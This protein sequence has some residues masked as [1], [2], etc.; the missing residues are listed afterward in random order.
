MNGLI[1]LSPLENDAPCRRRS[2]WRAACAAVLS[3]VLAVTAVVVGASPASAAGDAR[4]QVVAT[5]ID[6][7][8]GAAIS[9]TGPGRYGG[10]V[11]FKVDFSCLVA[12]CAGAT[13]RLDPTQLDPNLNHY[14]LLNQSGFVPP[15]MGATISGSAAA[16]YTVALGDLAAGQ[17]GSFTVEY[18]QA[19]RPGDHLARRDGHYNGW[20]VANFPIGFP[21]VQRVTGDATTSAGP[22]SH[23]SEPVLWEN[24]VPT[25]G[26]AQS[27][28]AGQY[29]TDT[30]YTY[31]LYMA[32]G[33]TSRVYNGAWGSV[34]ASLESLCAEKYE[35]VHRIP[36][37]V[38][39]VAASGDP[40]VSGSIDDGFVLTWQ[41]DRSDW[42]PTDN[43]EPGWQSL[44]SR[45]EDNA[46]SPRTVTVRFPSTSFAPAG[47]D[48][49]FTAATGAWR[50]DLTVGYIG[51]PGEE[52]VVKNSTMGGGPTTVRCTSEPASPFGKAVADAKTSTF[53]GTARLSDGDS[54][55]VVPRPG[56][57]DNEKQ[58]QVT[59]GN[60]AN[61]PG[62]AVVTDDKLDLPDAPVHRIETTP[63]GASVAWTAT[64]GTETVSGTSASP[65]DAPA[66]FRF[67]SAV[68]TSPSL[69]GPNTTSAQA[70][71]TNFSVVYKYR[72]S[73]TAPPGERRT[74]EASAVM[75][76]PSDSTVDDIA[77]KVPSHTIRFAKP[78]GKAEAAKASSVGTLTDGE[79]RYTI[80]TVGTAVANWSVDAHNR[81]NV[82]GR[83]V[84]QE[85]VLR[86]PGG[87]PVTTVAGGYHNGS[88]WV[89]SAF[90]LEYTLDDGTKG[91]A[92]VAAGQT[93]AAP[94][95]RALASARITSPE[96][97]ARNS[98]P[99][100]NDQTIFRA[101]FGYVIPATAQPDAV[102]KNTATVTM[103][104]PDHPSLDDI[105]KEVSATVRLVG[106]I[107]TFNAS[108]VRQALPGGA[109]SAGP[110]TTVTYRVSGS[111]SGV[112]AGRTITSQYVF[113]A[114]EGWVIVPGSASFAPGTVPVGV[115]F[116]Y[117][118]VT[119]DGVARQAV[120]AEWPAGTATAKNA[121]LPAMTVA[122][123]PGV[124]VPTGTLSRPDAFIGN[125]GDPVSTDVFATPLVDAPDVDR[126][127]DTT[128]RFARANNAGAGT[129]VA[130]QP[131]LQVLKEICLPDRG[132]ADGCEWI[133]DPRHPVGVAPNSTSIKYRLSIT[134]I[135]NATLGD[136]VGYD[137]LPY[138]GDTGTSDQT[139]AIQRGSTFRLSVKSVTSPTNG[140]EVEF[141]T[142]TQPCRSEV[143]AAVPG[144]ADDWSATSDGAQSI[145][146]SRQGDL[147]PGQ[148]ISVE[149]TGAVHDAPANG[150]IACNSFAV[151]AGSLATVSEPAA[152]CATIQETDLRIA[153]EPT[154]LQVGRP[155]VLPFTV[156]N[157]GGA[158]SAMGKVVV[159]IPKGV[160][161]T[162]LAPA[163]WTCTAVDGAGDPAFGTAVGP[164]TLTCQP[165]AAF[166]MDAPVAL[167]IPVIPTSPSF[168]VSAE[169]AGQIH[170]GDLTNNVA[171][172][173]LKPV[174]AVS[175]LPVSKNDGVA[176][177]APGQEL[178]YTIT[179]R[180]PLAYEAL[181][182]VELTDELPAD[183]E[184]ISASDGGSNSG[185]TVS[186]SLPEI[187]AGGQIVRSVTLRVLPT[188]GTKEMVNT[189]RGTAPDPVP[190]SNVTITGTGEDRD[191]VM[192]RPELSVVKDSV[193]K[194]FGAAGQ[195]IT[196]QFTV[197]NSGDV[198]IRDIELDDPLPGLT[199][200]KP[201]WPTTSG[202]LAPGES[203]TASATYL[204]TQDDID[205]GTL[206]NTATATGEAPDGSAVE[207]SVTHTLPGVASAH[208]LFDKSSSGTPTKAGD[209][210]SYTFTVENDGGVTLHDVTVTDVMPGLSEPKFS[211]PGKPN[212]LAPGTK[213]T[214][215]ASYTVRQSDVD[216]GRVVNSATASGTPLVGA[217]VTAEDEVTDLIDRKPGIS[218][219]KR[220]AHEEGTR[221]AVGDRLL[222]S[223]TIANTGNV[224]LSDVDI[225]DE[226]PGLSDIDDTWPAEKNV[227][228]PGQFATATAEYTITQADVDALT[229][230]VNHATVNGTA[231]DGTTVSDEASAPATTPTTAA[232]QIVE[233][234]TLKSTG[235]PRAGDVVEYRY[236]VTNVGDVT[237]HNVLIDP[238]VSKAAVADA[239]P[240]TLA[241]MEEFGVSEEYH[242]TQADIDAGSVQH[243]STVNGIAPDGRVVTDDDSSTVL[244]LQA[245]SV[246]LVK[247]G[248][249]SGS[250][251]GAAVGDTVAYTFEVTNTGNVTLNDIAIADAMPGLS[252]VE[253]PDPEDDGTLA[254]DAVLRATATYTLTAADISAGSVTNTATVT[255]DRGATA[256][257]TF[258]LP[259]AAIPIPPALADAIDAT[260][261][262]L[263]STGAQL[264]YGATLAALSLAAGLVLLVVRRRRGED[265]RRP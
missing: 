54:P 245:P 238:A 34:V 11:G 128:E 194:E 219:E 198:T 201:T 116:S 64:N 177:A 216:A 180:N 98:D 130:L 146:L 135:G 133:A 265:A 227:L 197:R 195:V 47:K 2:R 51:M 61:I 138:P 199:P 40:A 204:T 212:T 170:D 101:N 78:F 102:W 12:E 69:A 50:T 88:A 225:V 97:A 190:G 148:R 186:W 241:P 52:G 174:G 218:L 15:T 3:L 20:A 14:R 172:V 5:A 208:L 232:I 143:D 252:E 104:Y 6:P 95:G 191:R 259:T 153:A 221:G 137:V 110:A 231:P 156:S 9:T 93:F 161:V 62:V 103:T 188:I 17:S 220:V 182:G 73:S 85:D 46:A 203:A 119:L 134:N 31:K 4:L 115:Q 86:G 10:K 202:V 246:A 45:N 28:I 68:V 125:S 126:D 150:A 159:T 7:A 215:T 83:A 109:T 243:E 250:V 8:T 27:G 181:P 24:T 105:S 67:A 132:A 171:E 205:A 58:W 90:A 129:T 71:R 228:L 154:D 72:V 80:P 59:V 56:E 151:K 65:V 142:S 48:C 100:K 179:V 55:I 84:I 242:L 39:L 233:K 263:A 30:D 264:A 106:A 26:L 82:P 131:G 63:A 210:I 147:A 136:V 193:Q 96:L 192:T 121:G 107:S 230:V 214:A 60:Q 183:T 152:V 38:Q 249:R 21:I 139:A 217:S 187:P 229:G 254:P 76:Y 155:G 144:C 261:R 75:T 163:G 255:S 29:A 260:A 66:G 169:V 43:A 113:V 168:T 123:R 79:Y 224:T 211:W 248:A 22:L 57:A 149:Y 235:A 111:T 158:P 256:E 140:S 184:F 53:D 35:V 226:L 74:N 127:G 112:P 222:Y 92:D 223:F 13:V 166:T 1:G 209:V 16:G 160:T 234:A 162:D 114:P 258:V 200:V 118:T 178:T 251:L 25:P 77:L 206:V 237:L 257:D 42:A 239:S 244:L 41:R 145:R 33:C 87:L 165:G 89:G 44:S 91:T 141:S 122:A 176:Q 164:A 94:A 185:G 37:G 108:V 19:A 117:R 124:L 207:K 240:R 189:A 196:Y 70:K 120:V 49:D 81:G 253:Y 32:S 157:L 99:E 236:G 175:G 173:A 23:S 247:T 36:A 167:D 213:A 18:T 262:A